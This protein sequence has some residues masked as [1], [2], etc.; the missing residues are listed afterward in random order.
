M[1]KNPH[2]NVSCHRVVNSDGRIGGFARG[3][4]EKIRL[5]RKEGVKVVDG[6]IDLK[7]YGYIF[8]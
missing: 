3:V 8:K 4:S 2:K 5:L 1:N 7:K 6:R